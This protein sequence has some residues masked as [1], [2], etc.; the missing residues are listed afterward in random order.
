[1]RCEGWEGLDGFRVLQRASYAVFGGA[2]HCFAGA[3]VVI[4]NELIAGGRQGRAAGN[5]VFAGA[6]DCEPS[7]PRTFDAA[8]ARGANSERRSEHRVGEGF[9]AGLPRGRHSAR[10]RVESRTLAVE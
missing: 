4:A 3:S 9:R 8:F 10:R 2:M 6:S 7:L 5:A 1:M